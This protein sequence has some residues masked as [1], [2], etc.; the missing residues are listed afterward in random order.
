VF[1]RTLAEFHADTLRMAEDW[2]GTMLTLSTHDTKRSA[3]ARARI[4]LMSEL[5]EAW[6]T[7]VERLASINDARREKW[8]DR[9]AEYLFYQTAAGAW[10][11]DAERTGAF[12]TKA[13]REAKLHTSWL[14]PVPEYD[15][16]VSA[17]VKGALADRTFIQ[18]LEGFLS[19]NR[20]VELG[21]LN[22]LAQMALLL[23][24]PGVPDLYQGS[25]LWD[26]SLV[27][28]DNRRPVD[29]QLRRRLLAALPQ[30]PPGIPIG[31]DRHG[32]WK[33]WL[34][35]RLLAHRRHRSEL[36]D[37]GIYEP[38]DLADDEDGHVVAFSRG[39]L[40]V[41][42]PR[43]MA[44]H[45]DRHWPAKVAI[46]TGKWTNVLTGTHFSGGLVPLSE[47]LAGCPVAV[48]SRGGR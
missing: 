44:R 24:C 37:S 34:T 33:L 14:D 39:D 43:L 18:E 8:P 25:E 26:L 28:P 20:I 22:S 9:G 3:D 31:D 30:G 27:D 5:P 21:R 41:V 13:T 1:G 16:A 47:L 15:E 19:A 38:L 10:P 46:G 35:H 4:N 7:C 2:P 12:M 23:T 17:F 32:I 29:Y 36:Y 6:R 11:V 45:G 48:L 42:L 40:A